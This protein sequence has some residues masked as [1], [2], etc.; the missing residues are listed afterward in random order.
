MKKIIY[1]FTFIIA[2]VLFATGCKTSEKNT[3]IT[4]VKPVASALPV[5]PN[6]PKIALEPIEYKVKQ[7]IDVYFF[8]GDGCPYCAQEE[9]FLNQIKD[10]YSDCINIISYET[11]KNP[12]NAQFLTQ[13]SDKLKIVQSERG[14]PLT[15]IGDQHEVGYVESMAQ[16]LLETM[17]NAC[18][19]DNY[20]DIIAP[21]LEK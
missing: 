15:V 19:S 17:T 4:Y 20:V 12:T 16:G 11:W 8:Y 1:T 13:L 2:L 7:K 10:E 3:T 21:M 9:I 5:T 6:A 18:S 14:V